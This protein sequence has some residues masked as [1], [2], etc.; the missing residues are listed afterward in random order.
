MAE[1]RERDSGDLVPIITTRPGHPTPRMDRDRA[2]TYWAWSAERSYPVAAKALGLDRGTLREW[3]KLDDWAIRYQH[4]RADIVPANIRATVALSLGNDAPAA[5]DYLGKVAAG[6]LPGDRY[7]IQA[8]LAILDRVGFAVIHLDPTATPVDPIA[9]AS[10]AA[11]GQADPASLTQSLLD[12]LRHRL[13][14]APIAEEPTIEEPSRS[15]PPFSPPFSAPL[16]TP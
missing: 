8:C 12:K 7:R 15:T 4:D 6:D 10:T 2:Y 3:A 9:A 5:A 16:P 11:I 13:D 1:R 14:P